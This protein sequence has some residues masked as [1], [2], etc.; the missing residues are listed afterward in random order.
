[1]TDNLSFLVSQDVG[2][3]IKTFATVGEQSKEIDDAIVAIKAKQGSVE[4]KAGFD[5]VM[6]PSHSLV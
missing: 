6:L 4:A 3:V 5:P 2:G 1:M